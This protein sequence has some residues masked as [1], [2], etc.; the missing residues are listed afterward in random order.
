MFSDRLPRSFEKNPLTL[1]VEGRKAAGLPV[2][3]LTQSNPTAAGIP[4]P[5]A[6]VQA[7]LAKHDAAPYTPDPRGLLSAR[8]ALSAHYGRLGASVDAEHIHLT[9]G[10]S[11]AYAHLFKIL[12]DPGDRVLLP[13]PSYPLFE[14]LCA[15]E[16]VKT[17][18]F[19]LVCEADGWRIDRASFVRA[20]QKGRV[21]A[22]LFVHP[23]NPT[24]SLLRRE[25]WEFVKAECARRAIAVIADEVFLDYAEA[26]H[27]DA[28]G[29]VAGQ[30]DGPLL[31]VLNGLSKTAGLPQLKLAWIITS[32]PQPLADGARERLDIVNDTF[33]SCATPVQHAL[34]ELLSIGADIRAAIAARVRENGA[35]LQS[36]PWPH[37]VFLLPREAGW[38]AILKLPA[39][40][41]EEAFVLSLLEK[42]GV[43]AHP[44]FFYDFAQEA[45]HLV[46]G[47]L[48]PPADFAYG[49][50]ALART[51]GA[52]SPDFERQMALAQSLI[53]RYPDALR[54]LGDG[55]APPRQH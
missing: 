29:T 10:T 42:D 39:H 26:P 46:I 14:S 40:T 32:G 45:A 35:L 4:Y 22:V 48:T 6:R 2:C 31:F 7:A 8:Q 49:A 34:P 36:L 18:R 9:A 52:A 1:L 27:P 11:E 5:W 20:A 44:G 12:C 47:L 41:D 54:S 3:D 17:E 24:G 38:Y 50:A 21:R 28:I 55:E 37:E 19:W 53:K 33:L 30:A 13:A 16:G 43:L 51:L 23:N 15:L 25:D